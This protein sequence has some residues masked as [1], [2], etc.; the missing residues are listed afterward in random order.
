VRAFPLWPAL[1]ILTSL[2][3]AWILGDGL[4]GPSYAAVY[5]LATAPGLPLGFALFGRR[6]AAGWLS[7]AALGYG[8]TALALWVPLATGVPSGLAFLLAWA[9]VTTA[10]WLSVPRRTPL[11]V[12][13]A[14]TRRDTSALA[15]VLLLVPLLFVF[16][17]RNVG[18]ADAA[19]TRYYRAYFTADYLWH[20]ALTSEVAKFAMPPANPYQATDTVHYYWTYFLLP[21]AMAGAGPAP[22]ADVE[23]ALKI[24]AFCSGFLYAGLIA[25]V[26]WCAVPRAGPMAAA[27]ALTIVAASAEGAYAIYDLW[28]RG[29]P[30]SAVTDMNI[31]AVTAWSFDGLRIDGVARAMWYTPQHA[32]SCALGVI[33]LP[34]AAYAGATAPLG[35]IALAGLALGLSTTFNPLLGGVFSLVYGSVVLAD[36]VRTRQFKT[37]L[38]HGIAAGMVA[39]AIVW[40]LANEMFEGAGGALVFGFGGL[41]R[42]APVATLMLS[43]GVIIAAAVAG[44]WPLRGLGRPFWPAL[45]TVAA[46][47]VLF[48]G[49]R[50]D[51]DLAYVGFRAGQLL[52]IGLAAFVA[53]ALDRGQRASR[54]AVA[55]AVAIL[56]AAGVPTTAIDVYNAQDIGNRRMGPGFH[57]TIAVTPAEQAAFEW[58]RTHTPATAIVQMDPM[59]HGRE[60]W[61]LIPSFAQRRMAAGLPISLLNT[62]EYERRSQRVRDIYATGDAEAGWVAARRL[63]INYLY[64]GRAERAAIPAPALDKF[65]KH[66]EFFRRVF[67]NDDVRLYAVVRTAS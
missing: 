32:M 56:L 59:A 26:T 61:T 30:L 60:T 5:L 25:L 48:Y 58:I 1:G 66:P 17:Y 31:D 36:A 14:W 22:L 44:L 10:T 62:P 46:G 53:R 37:V 21:A 20:V 50:L 23:L 16:P 52:Q 24:N 4:R 54:I 35:G 6:H 45:A 57:W 3:T 38:R 13:P 67:A 18:A 51:V 34:V 7:G 63:R 15:G 41:A 12:L 9:A 29:H 11:V 40:S 27:V 65:E 49:V 42:N 28:A 2:A 64:V 47:L 8:L 55:A 33:A 43:L 39:L 19:G